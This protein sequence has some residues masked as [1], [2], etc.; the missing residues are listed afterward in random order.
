MKYSVEKTYENVLISEGVYKLSIKGKFNIKP[1]QFFMLK[2]GQLEPLLPRPISVYDVDDE[3]ISFLYQIVGQGTKHLSK[4]K[5]NDELQIMGPLGNGF[6]VDKIKGKIA[7][8]SGG[9]GIAPLVYLIKKL[10]GCE[11][12]LYSGFKTVDYSVD[13]VEKYVNKINLSTESGK[14]GHKGYITDILN[15]KDYKT[16]ICCGPEIM[17]RKVI[18]MCN[19]VFVPVYV[20]MEN[21]MACGIGACLVCTCKTKGGN[22]RTCKDGPVFNGKDLIFNDISK[23]VNAA[24]K[25]MI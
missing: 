15:P 16:V 10:T 2:T 3:K 25:E 8:V 21:H 4:L 18:T 22:K 7:V 11:I 6:E 23:V 12:D 1:G 20:S 14:I 19:D 17:M 13:S 24:P 5:E 9:I